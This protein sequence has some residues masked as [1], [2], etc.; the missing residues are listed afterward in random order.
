[1]RSETQKMK[2]E[3]ILNGNAEKKRKGGREGER[4]K[5]RERERRVLTFHITLHKK[6]KK[7]QKLIKSNIGKLEP[8]PPLYV[9]MVIL[10][11]LL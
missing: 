8:S 2:Q 5:E 1:M 7:G 3:I 10:L 11:Y 9:I 6:K 4:E